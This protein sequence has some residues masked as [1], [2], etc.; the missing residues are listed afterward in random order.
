MLPRDPDPDAP[1]RRPATLD[2]LGFERRPMVRW[3]SPSILLDAA[4]RV[5]VSSAFGQYADKRELQAA[6]DPRPGPTVAYDDEDT[7]WIDFV[8]DLGDGFDSTYAI[9]SL[10]GREALELGG[11]R[12]PR[13]RALVMGGDQVYPDPTREGYE[14]RTRGPYAAAL[15]WVGGARPHLLAIPGN[16]DW[17]DG[18]TNYL[19]FFCAGRRFGAWQT[20]QRRSY[21]AARLPHRWW[22][23]GIDIQLDTYIDTPQLEWFRGIGLQPGDR[24]VLV[25]GKPCWTKLRGG[26][27]PSSWKNIQ[28]F[29]EQVV[30]AAGAEVRALVSGD[31]HHYARYEAEDGTQLVTSGAGG[32]YLSPTDVLAPSLALP[33]GRRPQL[34]TTFPDAAT[35]RRLSLGAWRLPALAPGLA[36]LIGAV[37]AATGAALEAGWWLLWAV[38]AVALAAAM[39][40]YCSTERPLRRA[41]LGGGHGLVQA[42]L[43]TAPALLLDGAG[44]VALVTAAT[45]AL[46]GG[47]GFGLYLVIAHPYVGSAANESLASQAIPD[48]KGFLRLRVDAAGLTIFPVGVR[49]VPRTWEAAPD[50][51]PD[52]PF[53]RPVDRPLEA[54]L[55]EPPVHVPDDRRAPGVPVVAAGG[56]A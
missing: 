8:A 27:P 4:T 34:R 3:L 28:Y 9:A 19:R 56:S 6:L 25:T 24:V 17:Y 10:L 50:D 43:A 38:L 30:E 40:A 48:F 16:H 11:H 1:P 7:V 45:G 29:Q 22:V 33:D 37:H 18:L 52:A 26:P 47:L 35:S 41:L 51:P 13:G 55:I 44:L 2:E 21:F 46:L 15:P 23:L 20:V 14:H 36:A 12:L 54:E 32:A 42:A 5:V 49:R 39:V 31:L 53:L